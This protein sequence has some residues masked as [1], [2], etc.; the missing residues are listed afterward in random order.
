M[1]LGCFFEASRFSKNEKKYQVVEVQLTDSS[2]NKLHLV[3][4]RVL[5][6]SHKLTWFV[7]SHCSTA[8]LLTLTFWKKISCSISREA[9]VCDAAPRAGGGGESVGTVPVSGRRRSHS[10]H[11]VGERG[12]TDATGKVW[13]ILN[14]NKIPLLYL[15]I[16]IG[17]LS[18][19]LHNR[20]RYIT[21]AWS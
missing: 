19:M 15:T 4:I 17:R 5:G 11:R 1:G 16:L 9:N 10:H 3:D 18:Y 21:H 7:S 20:C 12:R 13:I 6:V 8:T 14:Y 2:S